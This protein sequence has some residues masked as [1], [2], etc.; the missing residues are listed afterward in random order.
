MQEGPTI[1]R[2]GNIGQYEA[3]EALG[4]SR[5]DRPA[6][7]IEPAAEGGNDVHGR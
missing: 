2:A 3:I 7:G 5:E 1:Q 4:H 6:A